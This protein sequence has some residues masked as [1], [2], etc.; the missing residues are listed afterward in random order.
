MKKLSIFFVLISFLMGCTVQKPVQV[1]G[2][3]TYLSDYTQIAILPFKVTFSNDYK[4]LPKR[5][6]TSTD[7]NEQERV[8][9][10][11]LQKI[12]L[13]DFSERANKK[14]WNITAQSH[15]ATNKILADKRIGIS[16]IPTAD[17]AALAKLLNVDAV[18]Y[19]SSTMDFSF[20][21]YRKGMETELALI[22]AKTGQILWKQT[23]FEDLNNR[24][25]SPQDLAQKSVASLI[26]SLP[27]KGK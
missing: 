14:N 11:D 12:C 15:L 9:G 7:W 22:D 10:L 23:F 20:N 4:T 3:D 8:A 27:I 2:I 24:M 5:G 26:K 17:K 25:D 6:R 21:A 1:A 18:L 13:A 19:G 16:E